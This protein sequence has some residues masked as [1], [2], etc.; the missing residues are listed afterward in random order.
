MTGSCKFRYA[1]TKAQTLPTRAT[2]SIHAY[3]PAKPEQVPP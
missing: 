1:V 2:H 3:T